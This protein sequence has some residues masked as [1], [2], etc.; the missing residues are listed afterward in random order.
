MYLCADDRWRRCP[1]GSP[2]G[3][4]PRCGPV[5]AGRVGAGT[6]PATPDRDWCDSGAIAPRSRSPSR[7][8]ARALTSTENTPTT[9]ELEHAET[10][11]PAPQQLEQIVEELGGAP[12]AEDAPLFSDFDVHPD[13]VAALAEAGITR[14]FAIQE[15]T[16]PLAL[17]GN[18]LI[19]QARTGTGKTLG[20]GVPMLQR[21]VPPA[22]GGD[23]VPQALVVVPTRELCV[24]VSRD[25]A[26]AGSKRGIRV[27]AIYGGRAFEPQVAAL[28]AGVEIVVG[29]PGRLL[30]LAQ[31]GDLILGKVKV[32]VLD[33]ADEMLDL[34]FLPDIER[35]LAM[36]PDKRQTMLFSATMPGPIVTLSRSFMTQPTHIRA[37]G[38]DEGSTVPQTTQFIYRAHNLDKPELLSR[39]LQARDRSLV[40]V[41]CRTKR[42][43][44]KVADELVERG[45]AAAAVHGDLGQGAREQALRAFRSG[46]VDVLVATDVAARGID[47]TGVSHVV[48]YQCPED[49]KT[50]LHRIGRTGRAGS[51]GVAVTL[52]DWDDIPRWQL[53]NKALEL[54]FTDPPETYSTSPWVYSDL[55]VPE[56]A[57]GRLPRSQ[58]TREGLDAE[59]VED[60]GETGKRTRSG[61]GPG[62]SRG[63]GRED[64]EKP[65]GARKSRPRRRTRGSGAAAAGAA[66]A[67]APA[68][69]PAGEATATGE[70]PAR[71]RR[72]R[73]RGGSGRGSA[74][75]AA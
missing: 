69:V 63:P 55:D 43:A 37:H 50:Y 51:E 65:E 41:F 16:L 30:D 7:P 73:R 12:V 75:P 38:N 23:G 24:Q 46:K 19:G 42:T 70:S 3:S 44:Q 48:N 52:V 6:D 39:V 18:D 33:E 54:D 17:A 2:P 28:Q 49:E 10:G 60:L 20:F 25:L 59:T 1:A 31:R 27:Q 13:V 68:E 56:G 21:V 66:A 61:G 5:S 26:T 32:L 35:I 8:E 57:T 67:D 29:T 71:K 15:L 11:A 72:R 74:E 36:V 9:P 4:T 34:G 53:I 14:T 47:V 64:D 62:A 22:E 58:R 45:F 40:M